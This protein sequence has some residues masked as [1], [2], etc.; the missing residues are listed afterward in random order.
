MKPTS[1]PTGYFKQEWNDYRKLS[2]F[3]FITSQK[4]LDSEVI[5]FRNHFLT[6][7]MADLVLRFFGSHF[8]KNIPQPPSYSKAMSE[9][10]EVHR[11]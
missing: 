10:S 5:L 6:Y 3:Y 9:F 4:L 1:R 11:F 2:N 7:V 8:L